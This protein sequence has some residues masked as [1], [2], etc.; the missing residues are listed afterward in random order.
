MWLI[1][2]GLFPNATF[3]QED[4]LSPA[5]FTNLYK[6]CVSSNLG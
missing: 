6:L 3:W 2:K 4:S 5:M 1:F